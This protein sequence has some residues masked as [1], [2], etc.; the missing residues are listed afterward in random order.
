MARSLKTT[1]PS[2]SYAEGIVLVL[3]PAGQDLQ[4]ATTLLEEA[5]IA[6][7]VCTDLAD[8]VERLGDETNAALIAEEAL[9]SAKA[10]PFLDALRKQP[11]WSD[12]PVI[13]LAASGGSD[14]TEYHRLG[15]FRFSRERD[16]A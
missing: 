13:V 11:P 8:L 16:F 2:D 5:R 7:H 10:S 9:A 14:G 4:L 1:M 6:V 15:N 3:A 12:L